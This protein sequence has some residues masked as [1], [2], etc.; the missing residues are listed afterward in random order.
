M[1]EGASMEGAVVAAG[2]SGGASS[3]SEAAGGAGSSSVQRSVSA[4]ATA[5]AAGAGSADS[6]FVSGSASGSAPTS[7][8]TRRLLSDLREMMNEPPEGCSAAP[9][10]E[11]NLYV[12]NASI[13]GPDESPWEGG[14]YGLRLHFPESYPSKPPKVRFT[15]EQ[16]HPNVYSDGSLCLDIIQD[17]WSPIYSVA[18][19]LTSIQ[20][21]LTDPN[22]N[23]PANPEAAKL[24]VNDPKEYRRRVRRIAAKSLEG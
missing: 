4:A 16:Y 19:I 12:W 10:K 6:S 22:P 8:S 14:I 21:L 24:Y 18:T 11:S 1:S 23:S 5:T 20:S 17:Q 2:A 13:I 3:A 7:A 9:V 15:C